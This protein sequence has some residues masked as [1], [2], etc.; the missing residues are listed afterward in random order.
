MAGETEWIMMDSSYQLPN[1]HLNQI[2]L[3]IINLDNKLFLMG[4]TYD[5][6]LT[7]QNISLIGYPFQPIY[8]LVD[9]EMELMKWK[10]V[11]KNGQIDVS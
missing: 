3:Q 1:P 9:D 7:S 8:E 5:L 2:D 4:T 6:E 10:E 11:E